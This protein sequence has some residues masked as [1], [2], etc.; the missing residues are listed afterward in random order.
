VTRRRLR[1]AGP[2]ALL[3]A[4]AAMGAATAAPAARAE[5]VVDTVGRVTPISAY[6]G[7][8]AWSSFDAASRTYRLRL[9]RDGVVTT[10]PV[11]ARRSPFDADV[12]PDAGGQPVVVY[13]RCARDTRAGI[14]VY[15]LPAWADARG[16]DIHRFRPSDGTDRV[17][18]TAASKVR[19]EMTPSIWGSRLAYFAVDEPRHGARARVARLYLADLRGKQRTRR[20]ATGGGTRSDTF[21]DQ[22]VETPTPTSLDL[23]GTTIA[24]GWSAPLRCGSGGSDDSGSDIEETEIWRQTP[25]RRT[26]LARECG[27]G[28][29]NPFFS[30]DAVAWTWTGNPLHLSSDAG[31]ETAPLPTDTR[32]PATFDG[33]QILTV[34][35]AVSGPYEVIATPRP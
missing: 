21:G 13:S 31:T 6:G 16:C 9:Y 8:A 24:Y 27:I 35:S 10:A 28:V 11:P 26:R 29:I 1:R 20:F 32:G 3:L 14:N 12:G 23:R 18:A 4:V 34:S 19:S 30:G 2:A 7:L 22:L 25:A 33:D 15:G 5:T 17:L